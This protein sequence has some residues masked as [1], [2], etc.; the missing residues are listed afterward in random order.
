MAIRA[1]S[2][3]AL[4]ALVLAPTVLAQGD[5]TASQ[6]AELSQREIA[7]HVLNRLAFGPRPGEVDD[8]LRRGWMAWVME[9]LEPSALD[10]REL[11]ARLAG[12]RSLA[13]SSGQLLRT[14]RSIY[15]GEPTVAEQREQN[16]LR[17]EVRREIREAVL[18]RAV[19]SKRQFQEVMVEFW[20]NHFNIDQD[21]DQCQYICAAYER[22]TIREHVFGRFEDML[23][24]VARHPAMLIYLDNY[25]SQKP[26]SDREKEMLER[27]KGKDVSG[28]AYLASL[29]R[30]RGL[31]ENFA[32]E[33]ME[34]HTL[35]VIHENQP[36]GY[37]QKDVIEVA[38]ALTGWSI[39]YEG[40]DLRFS[41]RDDVHDANA[42]TVQVIR[43]AIGARGGVE[44]GENVVT[45]LARHPGTAKFLA[46]KLCRYLV[47]DSPP[48]GLVDDI[49]KVYLEND[50]DLK[51]VY[52]AILFHPQFFRRENF[53]VKFK[54]PFEFTASA[55]RAT[56]AEVNEVDGCLRILGQMGQPVFHC[57]DPTGYYD[58]AEAWLDPGVLVYRWQF[59]L[60]LAANRVGG[61][62]MPA[63]YFRSILDKDP[64]VIQQRLM[65]TILPGGVDPDTQRILDQA[66]ASGGDK[67]QLA[68][69]LL[70]ML[71][72]S[73][74]FQQQ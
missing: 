59:A 16:R 10:D 62:R 64:K 69:R 9:Q 45:K 58:Q 61:V 42:K 44:E 74:T 52:T 23:M 67:H 65:E 3:A 12:H 6:S 73:P 13:M 57:V 2:V 22:E 19:F 68:V 33:L 54:T 66:M 37:T 8:V 17:E 15:A 53:R 11:E 63:D 70:G 18:L 40:D 21:K 47:N 49:A 60:D 29:A 14:Y 28:N 51:A 27:N 36:G 71:L 43:Y 20:R 24:A 25:L 1:L 30:Q 34:L 4:S 56:G 38:R 32:R 26:L 41:F 55:L 31:N 48:P 50:G 5:E 72:G 46:F 39:S 7:F 35:G